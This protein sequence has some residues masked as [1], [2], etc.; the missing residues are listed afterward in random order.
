MT[1]SIWDAVAYR[2]ELNKMPGGFFPFKSENS[3][4]WNIYFKFS[5]G[6]KPTLIQQGLTQKQAERKSTAFN[7]TLTGK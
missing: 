4:R 3:E 6:L 5:P 7:S 2:E 1:H